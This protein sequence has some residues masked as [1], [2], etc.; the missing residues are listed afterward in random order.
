MKKVKTDYEMYERHY[1]PQELTKPQI[2]PP[3]HLNLNNSA[4]FPGLGQ[5]VNYLPNPI[6]SYPIPQA[7]LPQM[8]YNYNVNMF[9]NPFYAPN[10]YGMMN[11][12]MDCFGMPQLCHPQY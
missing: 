4:Y 7:N 12:W 11:P 2:M 6:H 10:P 8:A 5:P 1:Y 3:P 9:M